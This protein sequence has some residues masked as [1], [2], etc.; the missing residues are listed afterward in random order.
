MVAGAG[1]KHHS[2]VFLKKEEIFFDLTIVEEMY[3]KKGGV[4]MSIG[5]LHLATLLL[6]TG[7]LI[8]C[9]GS[10]NRPLANANLEEKVVEVSDELTSEELALIA[11]GESEAET[12]LTH[13]PVNQEIP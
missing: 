7:L 6:L 13:S 8:G 2:F 3:K 12:A 10:E 1:P 9:S 5:R 4:A 11:L